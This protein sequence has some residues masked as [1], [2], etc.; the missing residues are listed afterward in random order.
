[1]NLTSGQGYIYIKNN[2]LKDPTISTRAFGSY[3]GGQIHVSGRSLARTWSLLANRAAYGMSSISLLHNP[4]E[5]VGAEFLNIVCY[6]AN[7]YS[8]SGLESWRSNCDSS[9]CTTVKG[10]CC[11]LHDWRIRCS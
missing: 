9:D 10:N 5:M 7:V 8:T 1:M 6:T 3:N 11:R 2:G 4:E